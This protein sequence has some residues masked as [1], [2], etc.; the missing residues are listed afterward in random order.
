MRAGGADSAEAL[1]LLDGAILAVAL[2]IITAGA[3]D[4]DRVAGSEVGALGAAHAIRS[5][6]AIA[7][8]LAVRFPMIAPLP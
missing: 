3:D 8:T 1:R 2:G 6:H 5:E 7:L 4:T